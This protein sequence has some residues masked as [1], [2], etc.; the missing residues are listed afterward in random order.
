MMRL[1]LLPLALVVLGIVGCRGDDVDLEPVATA[2]P[3]APAMVRDRLPLPFCG[4]EDVMPRGEG[5]DQD[6]RD[7]FVDAVKAGERAELITTFRTVEGDPVTW[8]LRAV[9]AGRIQVFRDNT[10]DRFGGRQGW[11]VEVCREF[12]PDPPNAIRCAAPTPL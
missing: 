6:A 1:L 5:T 3:G 4:Q 2:L 9:A 11:L 10:R 8:V 7:C 12:V